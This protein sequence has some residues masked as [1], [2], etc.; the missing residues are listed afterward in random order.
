MADYDKVILPGSEGRIGIKITGHKIHPGRFNKSFTV[1]TNDPENSK[2]ILSVSGIVKRVFELSKSMNLSGFANEK[3]ELESIIS[4]HLPDDINITGWHWAEKSKHYDFLIENIGVDLQTRE[5][6]KK[7]SLKVW[8]KDYIEPGR[9]LGD[10]IL[11]T[12]FKDIP[13]KKQM[14]SLTITPD[15]QLAPRTVIMREMRLSGGKTKNFEK[16]VSVIAA[17]GDSLQIL[18]VIPDRDDITVNV[19]E[20]RPGKAFSCVISIRPPAKSGRYEGTVTFITNYP[21]Y[22]KLELPIKGMVRVI[23]NQ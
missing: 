23:D 17:R 5:P 4:I 21:G 18:E 10:L 14:F 22:E 16:R 6:G 15:V 8:T 19:R 20:T 11:E 2:V 9:Y 3:L 12:D 1:K 13:E 7:Y